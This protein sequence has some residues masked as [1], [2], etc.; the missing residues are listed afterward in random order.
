MSASRKACA[1]ASQDIHL[2][3]DQTQESMGAN[4]D[5]NIQLIN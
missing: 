5:P 1:G 4:S 3:W 2:G